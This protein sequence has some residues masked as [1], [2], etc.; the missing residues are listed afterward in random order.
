VPLAGRTAVEADV[1]QGVRM[2]GTHHRTGHHMQ[3]V[4]P[5]HIGQVKTS[6]S[7]DSE[8][9]LRGVNSNGAP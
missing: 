9:G 5:L 6:A 4:L 8:V 1:H 2:G 3:H 7:T